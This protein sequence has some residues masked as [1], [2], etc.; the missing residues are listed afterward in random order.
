MLAVLFI[1]LGGFCSAVMDTLM[2]HYS[3]SVFAEYKKLFFDPSISW[4]NKWKDETYKTEKFWGSS[5]LF[6]FATDAWHLSKFLYHKF[7]IL[8]IILYTTMI[9][10]Y[11]DVLLL[12]IVYHVT[13]EL[14]FRLLRK[15]R[16]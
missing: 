11:V 10:F 14:C 3:T 5:T 12:I 16:K 8:A 1:I 7:V 13:F 4:K 9:S 6:V 2:F 15:R